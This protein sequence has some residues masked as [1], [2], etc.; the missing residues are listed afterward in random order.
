[1][2]NAREIVRQASVIDA[3]D[4]TFRLFLTLTC[5]RVE[6]DTNTLD[7]HRPNETTIWAGK[8]RKEKHHG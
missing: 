4:E 8:A 5:V 3:A 2:Q 1:M 6:P 7:G